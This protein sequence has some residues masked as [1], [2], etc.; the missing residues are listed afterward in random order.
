MHIHR[1]NRTYI[2]TKRTYIEKTAHTYIKMK[3]KIGTTLLYPPSQLPTFVLS[4][5][6]SIVFVCIRCKIHHYAENEYCS[7]ELGRNLV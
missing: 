3:K 2:E 4:F 5:N 6:Y 7:G 1:K